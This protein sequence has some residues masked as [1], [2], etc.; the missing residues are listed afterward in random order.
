MLETGVWTAVQQTHWFDTEMQRRVVTI[1]HRQLGIT[2][3]TESTIRITSWLS[4]FIGKIAGKMPS[5]TFDS[6]YITLLKQWLY[7]WAI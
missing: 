6:N 4:T 1:Q 3:P 7:N 2:Q 5:S